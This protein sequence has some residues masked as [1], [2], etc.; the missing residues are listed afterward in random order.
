MRWQRSAA[1]VVLGGVGTLAGVWWGAVLLVYLPQWSTSASRDLGLG[2]GVA[3]YLATMIFGLVLIVVMMVAPNGIQ[4]G[5]AALWR[6]AS[7][8]MARPRTGRPSCRLGVAC[9]RGADASSPR[10]ARRRPP[11]LPPGPRL[12][13]GARRPGPDDSSLP[14]LGPRPPSDPGGRPA[15]ENKPL[16]GARA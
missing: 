7:P 6:S 9:R 15:F 1:A 10:H 11:S 8:R 3:A 16:K 13:P 2:A 4:G 12:S 14:P 5:L